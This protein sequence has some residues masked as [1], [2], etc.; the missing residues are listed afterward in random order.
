MMWTPEVISLPV[1]SYCAIKQT[2]RGNSGL[3]LFYNLGLSFCCF[4][5]ISSLSNKNIE[6]RKLNT[7]GTRLEHHPHAKQVNLSTFSIILLICGAISNQQFALL[8]LMRGKRNLGSQTSGKYKFSLFWR[9]D[10]LVKI[11]R[12]GEAQVGLWHFT[13]RRLPLRHPP[14]DCQTDQYWIETVPEDF[15]LS[16]ITKTSISAAAEHRVSAELNRNA[17]LSPF[18]FVSERTLGLFL[19]WIDTSLPRRCKQCDS[20]HFFLYFIIP[21]GDVSL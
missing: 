7:A 8:F 2:W 13:R 19:S 11:A 6:L 9:I 18:V 15:S 4:G 20:L 10:G 21:L 5:I 1:M 12:L 3:L 17:L 14:S 16:F